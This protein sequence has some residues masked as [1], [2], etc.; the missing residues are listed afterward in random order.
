M[1]DDIT[2]QRQRGAITHQLKAPVWPEE[3]GS[4]ESGGETAEEYEGRTVPKA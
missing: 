2:I 4:Q 3:E 1:E